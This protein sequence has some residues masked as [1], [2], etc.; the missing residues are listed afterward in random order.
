MK[1]FLASK[2]FRAIWSLGLAALLFY[3][4]PTCFSKT[5]I[6]IV[7]GVLVVL[8]NGSNILNKAPIITHISR[9]LVGGLF[10]FSGFIKA[11]DPLGFSYKL[12]EYFEVFK[13]DSGLSIFESFA[14]IAL[15]LSI[16]LC[17]S[18]MALGFMLLIGY[19]RNLTLG[20]LL[21]QI[22]FFTF[23]TFYSACYNKVTTCGC[24]GDFLVLKPWTSF[25]K[26]IALLIL[27][28]LLISGKESINELFSELITISLT[29][30]A[31]VL[32]FVFPIHAYRN[33]PPFDFRPYAIGMNIK[34][35][36]KA[37]ADYVPAEYESGFIYENLKTGKQEHFNMKNYPWQDTLTWKWIATDNVLIHDAVHPPKIVDFSITSLDGND[38]KDSILNN[39]DYMFLLVCYDLTKTEDDETVHAKINDLYKLATA[40]KIK[41]LALTA[42]DAKQ[43]DDFKHKHQAMYDFANADG[44]VLKTM[45]RANPGLILIKDG[46]VIMNWHHNNFP[47]YSD[48]KQKYMK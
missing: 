12:Q 15:P 22:V 19:K 47:T 27:I 43:I 31:I 29:V 13:A 7:L 48:V 2:L 20:L 9:I 6:G 14:H 35:N 21:T 30:I 24:F 37:G 26:D 33:L 41:V 16:L 40:E 25:W 10:I 5:T 17:V 44:I 18:E 1:K 39:K 4:T 32:S 8:V 34:E 11:N 38:L 23:L 46:T 28:T 3:I 36:M 42:A 45:V